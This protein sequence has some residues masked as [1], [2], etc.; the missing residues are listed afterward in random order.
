MPKLDPDRA[1]RI[2]DAFEAMR[3]NPQDPLVQRAYQAMID[4]TLAQYKTLR[5]QGFEFR[6]NKP[7]ED[8][9]AAS[10]ALGYLDMR[11]RGRLYVFPTLEGF[12]SGVKLSKQEIANNPLLGDSGIKFGDQPATFNDIFRAVH[13]AYGHNGPGNPF[14]RAPGEERAWQ[15]HSMMYGPEGRKAMTTET[16]GQNS[17]LNFG[18]YGEQNQGKSAAD[19]VYADQKIGVLPEFTW[20]E[21]LPPTRSER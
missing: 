3:H 4:E 10:P 2:A 15:H 6:F 16:R 7:G 20:S 19:T 8:P 13:D 14:F 9:Y 12:G 21:G 17:W 18:P 11:D 1:R 5:N